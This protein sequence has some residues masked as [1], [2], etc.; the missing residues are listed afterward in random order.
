MT[1]E[2]GAEQ[3]DAV[4]EIRTPR[5]TVVQPLLMAGLFLLIGASNWTRA[6]QREL[7]LIPLAAAGVVVAQ[8][9]WE[10]T[11]GVDLTPESVNLRGFRRRSIAWRDVQAV[12]RYELAGSRTVRLI[13][14]NGKP[15]TLRAPRSFWRLGAAAYERD[16]HRIGQCWLAH[17]GEFWRPVRPEA[18]RPPVQG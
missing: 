11:W 6:D 14:E 15:V 2:Q 8:S 10:L 1:I 13:P 17:R 3:A 4:V 16:F 7:F 9:L 18:P 5:Y 12:L